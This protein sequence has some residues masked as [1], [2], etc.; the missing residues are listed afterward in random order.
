M[1]FK[2]WTK[3]K[4]KKEKVLWQKRLRFKEIE[5]QQSIRYLRMMKFGNKKDHLYWEYVRHV[6]FLKSWHGGMTS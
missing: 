6:L 1:S 4:E 2:A 3:E 5:T